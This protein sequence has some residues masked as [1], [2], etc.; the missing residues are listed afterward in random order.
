[1][2][3]VADLTSLNENEVSMMQDISLVQLEKEWTE[4]MTANLKVPG[5]RVNNFTVGPDD[6]YQR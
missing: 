1:M 3:N 2:E 6:G 5:F 4:A